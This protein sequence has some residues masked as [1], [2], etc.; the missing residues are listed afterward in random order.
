[1]KA[2]I[3]IETKNGKKGEINFINVLSI[4]DAKAWAKGN[5][6]YIEDWK[7]RKN[8]EMATLT[9]FDGMDKKYFSFL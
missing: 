3:T 1:M 7:K 6:K 9:V 5:S 2:Y 4:E 8:F